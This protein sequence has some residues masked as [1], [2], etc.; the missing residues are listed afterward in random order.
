MRRS[1]QNEKHLIKEE[2]A[3][4]RTGENAHSRRFDTLKQNRSK[5][6]LKY[7]DYISEMLFRN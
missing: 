1:I 7:R 4:H 6:A 3:G 5:T 2:W